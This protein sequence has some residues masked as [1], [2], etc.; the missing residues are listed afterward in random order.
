MEA[1]A[2]AGAVGTLLYTFD[3]GS[4]LQD[5]V[6]RQHGVRQMLAFENPGRADALDVD[7]EPGAILRLSLNL[8]LDSPMFDTHRRWFD[9]VSAATER[10]NTTVSTLVDVTE[11][12]R[13]V[14]DSLTAMGCAVT[15]SSEALA[16]M[17]LDSLRVFA[18]RRALMDALGCD[19]PLEELGPTRTITTIC[20]AIVQRSEVTSAEPAA[21]HMPRVFPADLSERDLAHLK[22]FEHWGPDLSIVPLWIPA[23][24]TQ[25]R[26]DHLL[27]EF[28]SNHAW[29]A[30]T[31]KNHHWTVGDG[32]PRICQL[33]ALGVDDWEAVRSE[34]SP[35]RALAI[36]VRVPRLG[37]TFLVLD[38]ILYDQDVL[39]ELETDF[40]EL[41][42][43]GF[44]EA[45][46]Q[47]AGVG[48]LVASSS[49]QAADR[50]TVAPGGWRLEF[51]CPPEMLY[52][53]LAEHLQRWGKAHN[54]RT[55]PVVKHVHGD[56]RAR[57]EGGDRHR[58]ENWT[59][60]VGSAQLRRSS[61]T[62]WADE[63]PVV[64]LSV[65][66]ADPRIPWIRLLATEMASISPPSPDGSCSADIEVLL[67]RDYAAI[68]VVSCS[69][70]AS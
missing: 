61:P 6:A 28:W 26:A 37:I 34:F 20:A 57:C 13:V 45:S 69:H 65:V 55:L 64:H 68:S 16:H 62:E 23:G 42:A 8:H 56:L 49:F 70:L 21:S 46:S 63:S 17:G 18:L 12:E 5:E 24:S 15:S 19:V 52:E 31:I 50:A 27:G 22:R 4:A 11:V 32:T 44:G 38:H 10:H 2:P 66:E 7:Y 54:V 47:D 53:R 58:V 40:L 30:R 35:H 3:R 36:I 29:L 9:E 41:S 48:A 43:A 51:S 39:Y 25:Q 60:D 33:Q 59:F 1:P 67:Q 14:R